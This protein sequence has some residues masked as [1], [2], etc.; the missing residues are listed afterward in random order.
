MERVAALVARRF[1]PMTRA[2]SEPLIRVPDPE[3]LR[4]RL[5]AVLLALCMEMNIPVPV[6]ACTRKMPLPVPWLLTWNRL[7]PLEALAPRRS[8][9]GAVPL[10]VSRY[11]A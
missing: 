11:A 10:W 8:I 2:P 9:S 6:P 5:D 7:C 1:M 4:E 3:W